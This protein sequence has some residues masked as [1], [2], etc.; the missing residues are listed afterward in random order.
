MNANEAREL[1]DNCEVTYSNAKKAAFE[2]IKSQAE[3]GFNEAWIQYPP[4][5]NQVK[6]FLDDFK[7][8]GYT[9]ENRSGGKHLIRW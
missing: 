1:S 3:I 8:L 9:I 2:L 5:E 4:S 6:R 7:E